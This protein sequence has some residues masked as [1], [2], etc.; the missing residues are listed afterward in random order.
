MPYH[1]EQVNKKKCIKN[2]FD[3][4]HLYAPR[5]ARES[6]KK[7]GAHIWEHNFGAAL[8]GRPIAGRGIA[9]DLHRGP[10]MGIKTW[11]IFTT[12]VCSKNFLD[13]FL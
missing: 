5:T 2:T 4:Q 9:G 13:Y 12:S 7:E 6:K 8:Q 10:C 11:S 3:I 1:T